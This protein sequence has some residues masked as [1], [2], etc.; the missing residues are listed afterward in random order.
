MKIKLLS[1]K[2]VNGKTFQ[3]A[4]ENAVKSLKEKDGLLRIS[5][6]ITGTGCPLKKFLLSVT[7]RIAIYYVLLWKHNQPGLVLQKN[8]NVEF[9]LKEKY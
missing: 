1:G 9:T 2:L 5:R 3:R 6:G 7:V 8:T 4:H